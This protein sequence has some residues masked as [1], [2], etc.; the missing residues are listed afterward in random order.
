MLKNINL[1]LKHKGEWFP[2][3][4]LG[5][6]GRCLTNGGIVGE[7]KSSILWKGGKIESKKRTKGSRKVWE[8]FVQWSQCKNAVSVKDFQEGCEWKWLV[9][10]QSERV[11]VKENDNGRKKCKKTQ[12]NNRQS[13]HEHKNAC[14]EIEEQIT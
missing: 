1:V 3:E 12:W 11:C 5:E 2:H 13:N 4:F 7:E 9:N 10:K 6:N 14:S 8:E